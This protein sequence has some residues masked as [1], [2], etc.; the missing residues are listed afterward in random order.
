VL[1]FP[2]AWQTEKRLISVGASQF[3]KWGA[4]TIDDSTSTVG[5]S[6]IHPAAAPA[7]REQI[8]AVSWSHSHG[9]AS[10]VTEENQSRKRQKKAHLEGSERQKEDSG[11]PSTPGI[12]S[13][14][15][16]CRVRSRSASVT[17][18][19]VRID[20]LQRAWIHGVPDG[21]GSSEH[22]SVVTAASMP[23]GVTEPTTSSIGRHRAHRSSDKLIG[24]W[25]AENA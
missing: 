9:A 18:S 6:E 15:R 8:A 2:A 3:F 22:P 5:E 1:R 13:A 24:E 16:V 20:R 12:M 25:T 14:K 11:P 17:L 7:A 4:R 23:S 19:N 10:A 21:R